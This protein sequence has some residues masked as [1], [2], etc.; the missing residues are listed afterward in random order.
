MLRMLVPRPADQHVR[1]KKDM[2]IPH[3]GSRQ[4][5]V[6][7]VRYR[8]RVRKKPTW[9]QKCWSNL[10]NDEFPYGRLSF[11]VEDAST[12][13]TTLVV[14][15]EKWHPKSEFEQPPSSITPAEVAAAIRAALADGWKPDRRGKPVVIHTRAEQD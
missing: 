3:K 1:R 15:T 7:E 10:H 4:I 6:D 12:P 8:W 13:G 14:F 2:A 5:T 11:A 9:E